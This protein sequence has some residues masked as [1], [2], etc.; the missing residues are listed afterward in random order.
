MKLLNILFFKKTKKTRVSTQRVSDSELLKM[1]ISLRNEYFPD[2]EDLDTYLVYWSVRRQKRVLASCNF[3]RKKVSVAK[4][5]RDP[6]HHEWLSPLLYHEMCHAV[7][8]EN[9]TISNGKRRWHGKMFKE[10]EKKHPKMK[11]FEGWIKGGGWRYAVR[12]NRALKKY[13]I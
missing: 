10:L 8:G 6:L 7:I 3:R 5:L 11:E 1:W 4:E 2:R 13:K 9:I 12:R